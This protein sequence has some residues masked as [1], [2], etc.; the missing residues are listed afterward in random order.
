MFYFK[1]CDYILCNKPISMVRY[2]NDMIHLVLREDVKTFIPVELC[3]CGCAVDYADSL[4]WIHDLWDLV[5]YI[6]IIDYY[7]SSM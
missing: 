5:C 4:P 7:F 1:P 3:S 6:C 2:L